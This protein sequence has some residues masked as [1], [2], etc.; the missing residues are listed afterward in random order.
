MYLT[1]GD[2]MRVVT[3]A[4]VALLHASAPGVIRYDSLGSLQWWTANAVDASCRW[5]VPVF[6][7]LSGALVLDPAR[8]ESLSAFYR[9][10]FMRVGVPLVVWTA[11]YF[12]WAVMYHDQRVTVASVSAS[13]QAGLVENHL[14]FLFVILGL[15][16]VAPLLRESLTRMG[17]A[18]RWTLAVLLLA[19]ASWGIPQDYWPMNAFTLFTPY[20]GYFIM[21]FLLREI[22]LSPTSLGLVAAAFAAACVIITIGTG[23][24]FAAWGPSDYRALALYDY[25]SAGV[26]SQ[27]IGAY[28]LIRHLCSRRSATGSNRWVKALGGAAFGI[29][30]T[31]RAALDVVAGWTGDLYARAA[32]AAIAVEALLA[33]AFAAGVTLLLQRL[34]YV[35]RA[36][37]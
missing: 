14:Y 19:L 16:A 1:Y 27:S 32:G 8:R 18:A 25:L 35:R 23:M 10:R 24:R 12:V 36:V 7:M 37:G 3:V 13:L 15:Y 26:I 33:F 11:F 5:A 4:A 17:Q 6:L 30:L 22:S 20:I 9:R 21:G 28:L 29:Y 2:G 34:P 31:H